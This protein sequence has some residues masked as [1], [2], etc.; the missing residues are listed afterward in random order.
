MA[1][2]K[3]CKTTVAVFDTRE[4]AE[5]AV[6]DLRASGYRDDQIGIVA[7]DSRGNTVRTDGAGDNAAE[8]AAVG[9]AAG[10]GALAL[11][12]LAVSFGII[13]VIGPILAVGPLA[14]ALI[15]AVGGAAAGGMAGALIG[16]GIPEGEAKYYEGQ[17]EAGKYLVTVDGG[18]RADD[19]RAVYTRHGG[20]DHSTAGKT[21]QLKEE[22]L[23]ASKQSVNAGEV[24]VHKEVHTEHK[25]IT[26]PVEREE[27]VI[28]RRPASGRAASGSIGSEEIRIP[29]REEKVH[30]NKETVLKEEVTIATRKVKGTETVSGDVRKEELVVDKTGDAKVRQTKV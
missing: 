27:V 23:R 16:L 24:K 8:G 12:S 2:T 6:N 25:Q 4:A 3:S 10:A 29:V 17:V 9:A 5:N 13:P 14:A 15:S 1:T 21:V 30:V 19:A 28:E 18:A 11:G 7:R 22:Q 20:Y 26:V